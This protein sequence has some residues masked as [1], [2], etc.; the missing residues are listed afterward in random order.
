MGLTLSSKP[1]GATVAHLPDGSMIS[2]ITVNGMTLS[3]PF[4]APPEGARR[5]IDP[6]EAQ[7]SGG[8]LGAKFAPLGSRSRIIKDEDGIEWDVGDDPRYGDPWAGMVSSQEEFDLEREKRFA[9]DNCRRQNYGLEPDS[10]P[11][12]TGRLGDL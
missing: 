5:G 1:D 7:R 8:R 2:H 4:K 12:D 3:R 10:E 11:N 9:S 6:R